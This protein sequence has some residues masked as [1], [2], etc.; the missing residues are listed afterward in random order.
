MSQD[1]YT[2][3]DNWEEE[4]GTDHNQEA[5]SDF[6]PNPEPDIEDVDIDMPTPQHVDVPQVPPKPKALPEISDEDTEP[7]RKLA[8]RPDAVEKT[9]RPERTGPQPKAPKGTPPPRPAK[10]E[11][12]ER[13][14][15]S[16]RGRMVRLINRSILITL[17]VLSLAVVAAA[18]YRFLWDKNE[19]DSNNT[20]QQAAL[21]TSTP[22][23]LPQ[24]DWPLDVPAI[25][26]TTP[27]MIKNTLV[28]PNEKQGYLF[29]GEAG[30]TWTITVES[31]ADD[32]G[33]YTLDPKMT[34][35]DPAGQELGSADDIST[36]NFDAE[37]Q[38][39]LPATGSY[40]LLVESS[41]DGTTTGRYLLS[42]WVS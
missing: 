4:S 15:L 31:I 18:A 41:A 38:I 40:R 36:D 34:L 7:R 12:P 42:L 17:V 10:K 30:Q 26:N 19:G 24:G 13:A 14:A 35:Y 1:D 8:S 3:F 28:A 6:Y 29:Q 25:E 2:G 33:L 5:A 21:A 27:A 37:L 9:G 11:R 22:T 16:L 32:S 39:V 20:E 23:I